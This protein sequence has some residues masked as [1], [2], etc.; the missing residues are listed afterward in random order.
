M[1][2][3]KRGGKG[4]LIHSSRSQAAIFI[5]ISVI[6][7]LSGVLY[8]FYQRQA[9]EK[10][11]EVVQPEAAP[12]KLYVEDC[13]KKVTQDG[14]E[15]IGLSGGY[16]S[17][18]AEISNNPK[19]YLSAFPASSFKIPYWW[20][21]GL[22]AVPT[23][24]FIN[25]QLTSHIKSELK[26]CLDN[27]R[28]FA[29][30]FEINELKDADINVQF[31][32]NDVSV[33]L[34]YPLEVTSRNGDFRQLIQNFEYTIPIRLKKVYEL[35]KLIMERENK[36]YFLEKRTIDLYSMDRDIPTTDVEATCNAKIWQLSSI[37]D[38][39]RTLLRVNIPYIRIG[40]TDYN[41]NLYVPNPSGKSVYS[42]TY[43]Q[44]HYIW[45]IGK[46]AEKKY[47]NMK[48]S[49]AYEDWPLDIFARPSQNG[50]L[51]SNSQKGTDMLS[52]FCMHIW[53]FTYDI[54]Y[55]V[56]V[57]VFDKETDSNRAYQFSFAFRVNV[58]HNRPS[59][60]NS[61]A[62]LFETTADLPSDE[63]CNNV[64]N[65]ITIFT[66]D[67]ATGDDM[68]DVNL[69]FVC[70][71]F[72]CGIGESNWLGLGGAA[73]ITKRLPY[74]VNAVLKGSKNGYSEAKT[75]IQTDVDGRSYVLSLN[76]I[77]E[78]NNY[79]V[80]KHSLSSPGNAQELAP[81][82]KA[83][84]IIRG[85]DTD[86]EAFAVYPKEAQFPLRIPTGKDATYEV[87]IYI[88]DNENIIGGYIGDWKLGKDALRGANEVTFHVIE[89]GPAT[90]DERLLFVS[91]LSSYSKNVPAP[92]LR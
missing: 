14:L 33:R 87:T 25:K 8:F 15:S 73:G 51:R 48:V 46:D 47:S 75:F 74:C 31:N 80:L 59:R 20:H 91:G 19:A 82:E 64:Q 43:F 26:N 63:Y 92:E 61:G 81:N 34:K 2:I 84:I 49:F 83:S 77:K 22:D 27:F 3:K 12:V 60:L 16:I 29:G 72:S 57:T 13:I 39:L 41:P 1:H 85:K 24:E 86:Y 9:A 78:L 21:D 11:V 40:G 10:E 7:I 50:I 65:E 58:D 23:E 67:S 54:S 5:I 56:L 62:T 45:D 30:K 88:A 89:Q 71:G 90:E 35:A 55:P 4:I 79:R 66:V 32:E 44:Y 28:P 6:I 42:Q 69:T 38:K 17:M 18:P 70:G 36:D 68:R 53:H 52:F 37:K 76:P